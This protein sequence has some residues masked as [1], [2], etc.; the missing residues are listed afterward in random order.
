[1]RVS[2]FVPIKEN[3]KLP[4]R[5]RWIILS[6]RC[7][8]SAPCPGEPVFILCS[9]SVFSSHSM[10][11]Y[12]E[13]HR[14]THLVFESIFSKPLETNVVVRPLAPSRHTFLRRISCSL[15]TS[16]GGVQGSAGASGGLRRGSRAKTPYPGAFETNN[17]LVRVPV[18]AWFYDPPL[19]R[20]VP[21]PNVTHPR[22]HARP[23]P[24]P[25][26]GYFEREPPA[27]FLVE[28]SEQRT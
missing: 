26:R 21:F 23:P 8:L 4:A 1:M 22:T 19:G 3:L 13:Q 18:G 24:P 11:F 12:A 20:V 28:H 5:D 10:W 15:A 9:R 2:W 16:G 17:A 7:R 14:D 6:F 25:N 27:V